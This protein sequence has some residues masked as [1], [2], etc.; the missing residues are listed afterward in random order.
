[1]KPGELRDYLGTLIINDLRMSV[2]IWGPPGVD[3]SSI[4]MQIVE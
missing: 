2:M 4:V 3:K 1:V